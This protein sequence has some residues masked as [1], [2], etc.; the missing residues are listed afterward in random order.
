TS[1]CASFNALPSAPVIFFPTSPINCQL[2]WSFSSAS[3]THSQATHSACAL[4]PLPSAASI[5][6]T[7][8]APMS[9]TILRP[10]LCSSASSCICEH[11]SCKICTCRS[12]SW[13]YLSHSSF[14]SS[15]CT[16]LS[17]VS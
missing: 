15:C 5:A 2:E 13:W 12:V 6:A 10:G 17:A 9:C 14:R 1:L 16:H 8:A 11:T 7:N 3:T 4:S